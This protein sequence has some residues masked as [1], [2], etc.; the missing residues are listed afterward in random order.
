MQGS[1]L[2]TQLLDLALGWLE[3]PGR[4]LW[5]G[6]WS[7]NHGAQRLYGR[8]GFAQVG[9]YAFPVGRTMDEDLI[10]ARPAP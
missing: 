3:A 5:L 4:R 2:G 10:F 7:R 6:V 8:R 1:G 9:E